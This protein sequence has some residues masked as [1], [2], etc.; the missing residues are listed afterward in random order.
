LPGQEPA[1][2][3]ALPAYQVT[4]LLVANQEPVGTMDMPVSLLRFEPRVDLQTRNLA[5]AQSDIAIRGGIFESSGFKLGAVSLYDPQT[6]HYFAEVP[7]APAMLDSPSIV[8]GSDNALTGFNAAVGTVA[9]DWRAIETRGESSVAAGQSGFNRQAFYEGVVYPQKILGGQFAADVEWARSA[10]DGSVPYGDHNFQRLAGRVQHRTAQSQTDL[11]AGYQAKFFGWPNLYTPFGVDETE[12]L[13]TVLV[14]LNHRWTGE[15]GSR[16]E[17]G[18]YYRRNTDDYEF[19]RFIPGEFNPYQHTTWV[20]GASLQGLQQFSDFSLNYSA[21]VMH[22]SLESTSLVFGPYNN[23]TIFKLALEPEKTFKLSDG[24]LTLRGGLAYDDSDRAKSAVSPLARVQWAAA[25]GPLYYLEYSEATQLPT[26]TALKSSPTSGL[27]RGNQNLGRETSRNLEFGVNTKLAGWKLE[28]AVFYRW[29]DA[30]VDW[31]FAQG[32]TARSA[33][34]V[35]IGTF[36]VEVVAVHRAK[37]YDLVLGYTGLAKNA[38]YGTAAVDAS[39]YALNFPRQ[40][41]T[42]ALTWR[43]GGGWEIRSDNEFR[44]QE[45]NSLRTIGGDNAVLSTLGLHYLPPQLHGWEFSVMVDNLWDSKF[46]PL[47]A[48]PAAPRQVAGSVALRW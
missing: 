19:N 10:S 4:P 30:L 24:A 3:V 39:F 44:I 23:R 48:V 15:D 1:A 12:D 17:V 45:K 11:F 38:D 14:A 29:D 31:T 46:Q 16:M 25:Q 13:H 47:P 8:T 42:A 22:D 20:R 7:V 36:G 32:V 6:G 43:F 28:A 18:A 27:F 33:N 35:N 2:A 41:L 5:E 26:Y 9:Y 21:Q 37:N 40:R 34:P